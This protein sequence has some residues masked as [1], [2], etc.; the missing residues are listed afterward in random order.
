MGVCMQAITD[1]EVISER[2]KNALKRKIQRAKRKEKTDREDSRLRIAQEEKDKADQ[3]KR[4][5]EQRKNRYARI[6]SLLEV[7]DL[8]SVE[9]EVTEAL[10]LY[11]EDHCLLFEFGSLLAELER[12]D[13]A[14]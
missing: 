6:Q 14:L 7:G 1:R 5:E 4:E 11:P 10:K 3:A 8:K 2:E 12:F 9:L 13:E